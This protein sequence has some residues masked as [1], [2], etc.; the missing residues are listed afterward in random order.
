MHTLKTMLVMTSVLQKF[1][2]VYS[3]IFIIFSA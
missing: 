3:L 1:T 2:Q